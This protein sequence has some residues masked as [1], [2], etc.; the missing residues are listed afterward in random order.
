M[1]EKSETRAAVWKYFERYE[2][3]VVIVLALAFVLPGLW[4]Y[5]LI[6]PWETHYSEVARRMLQDS[7]WVHLKWQNEVFRSK[8]VLTF[9]LIAASL[10]GLGIATDGGYSGEMVT[11][12]LVPFAARLPFALFGAM[13]MVMVWW[14]LRRLVSRRVAWLAFLVVATCPMYILVSR[15]AITDMPA[16]AS[17]AGAIACLAMA[18]HRGDEPLRPFWR[19]FDAMQVFLL[20]AGAFI[21]WQAVYYGTYFPRSPRLA[22]GIVVSRPGAILS[23]GMLVPYAGIVAWTLFDRVKTRRQVYLYWFW[24]LLGVSVLAKGPIGP[25]SAAAVL[26]GYGFI[27]GSW[28]WVLQLRVWIEAVRGVAVGLL[29][30]VPWHVAMWWKDGK[31]WS[32]EYF[33]Y[34]MGKRMLE[35]AHQ[36]DSKTTFDYFTSQIGVGMWPWAALLPFALAAVLTSATPRT[37]DGQM[38][39]LCGIWAI[40]AYSLFALS[41]TKFHHYILPAIPAF[42]CLIAFWIDDLLAGR[43]RRLALVALFAAGLSL[44]ISRDLLGEPKQLIE[45]FIY[46]YDRPWPAGDPWNVDISAPLFGFGVAGAAA[47]L[48]LG[49]PWRQARTGGV[50]A[51]CTVAVGFALW[52]AHSYM[53]T[54]APHWGQRELHRHYLAARAIHGVEIRYTSLRDLADDWGEDHGDYHVDSVLPDAFEVGLPQRIRLLVPGAGVPDDMVELQGQVARTGDDEFW[55]HIAP[56]ER[57]KLDDLVARGR[58]AKPS[59]EGPWMQVD[60][61]RLI[62]WQLNWRGENFWSAG[63]IY[64]ATADTRT[65]F[66]NTNNEEFLKYV[67]DKTRE[68]RHF[69]VITEAAR[70]KGLGAVLP[71]KRGKETVKIIDTSCNKFT[72]LEFTL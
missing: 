68:G 36:T 57:S 4:A 56:E 29:V 14:M 43:G 26:A 44:L 13:G 63:E 2:L 38:R 34:H 72:L 70:A 33:G 30:C 6:D 31:A 12:D 41:Q 69:F 61:D 25:L 10:G 1:S 51:L 28:A 40:G 37:R 8:P 67:K 20:V 54:A 27:R 62:A 39:L 66:I 11:S 24:F 59:P 55:I 9:W 50:A 32:S 3:A 5:Q 52:S 23:Y 16:V 45:M 22:N 21:V 18:I 46:R 17:L 7:D 19:R 15:Q 48:M 53:A 47:L 49:L 35:G 60:A 71:T 58:K 42:A 65:V 64:G